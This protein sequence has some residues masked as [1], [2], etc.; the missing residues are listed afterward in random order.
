MNLKHNKFLITL[1]LMGLFLSI[2]SVKAYA[3]SLGP[4]FGASAVENIGIGEQYVSSSAESQYNYIFYSN[5]PNYG[6]TGGNGTASESY[7]GTTT[8]ANV[9]GSASTGDGNTAT[10]TAS[11]DLSTGSTHVSNVNTLATGVFGDSGYVT[12]NLND[13]LTFTA[14]GAT[15]STTTTI[16]VTFTIDGTMVTNFAGG[17][18]AAIQQQTS[19]NGYLQSSLTF[20]AV[21]TRGFVQLN[22]A[23][24]YLAVASGDTYPSTWNGTWVTT[25]GA[26]GAETLTFNGNY[27]FTGATAVVPISLDTAMWCYDGIICDFG[28]TQTVA[29]SLPTDVSFTSASGVFLS[30]VN[31]S[32]PEPASIALLA[33][34]LI[35][36]SA[37]HRKKNKKSQA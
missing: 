36:F 29:L 20:G 7:S 34:G 32:V 30:A 16:G 22:Q 19:V 31:P 6:T 25:N 24:G 1:A 13:T 18:P 9:T 12:A 3:T 17:T 21:D 8:S 35:G 10:A 37:S 27:S 15:P 2:A 33:S 14:A 28:N 4:S 11:A 5:I 23:T 26:N